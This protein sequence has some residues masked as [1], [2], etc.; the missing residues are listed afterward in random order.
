MSM[1][2]TYE[3]VEI[4]QTAMGGI[5]AVHLRKELNRMGQSGWE[6]VNV[7]VLGPMYAPQAVFKKP[8]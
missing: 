2:W 4:K 1:P 7:I 3:V 6:L 8:A 5:D